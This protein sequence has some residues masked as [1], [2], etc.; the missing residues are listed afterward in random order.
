M[1]TLDAFYRIRSDLKVKPTFS[2]LESP[3]HQLL[4]TRYGPLDVL[5]TIGR[6]YGYDEL[7]GQTIELDA[8][9]GLKVRLLSLE[10][11]IQIKEDLA[12]EQDKAVLPILRRTLDEKSRS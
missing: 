1:E 3:G 2:H 4:M 12:R 5:G 8:S 9:E 6:G 7:L 10:K 11:H